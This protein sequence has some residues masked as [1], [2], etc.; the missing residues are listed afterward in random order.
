MRFGLL[1]QGPII[2]T[3]K[4]GKSITLQASQVKDEHIVSHDSKVTIGHIL[5]NYRHLF[6]EILVS[7]WDDYE[8]GDYNLDGVNIVKLKE[9]N[10]N[11]PKRKGFHNAV[12]SNNMLRQFYG[13]SKGLNTF[14]N[15]VDFIIRVRTDQFLNLE[16][17]VQFI[18]EY[19]CSGKIIIP[20]I[21][22][23]RDFVPDFYFAGEFDLLKDFFNVL[24]DPTDIISFSP[25]EQIVLKYAKE[26]YFDK[27]GVDKKWY[28]KPRAN[29]TSKIF[30]YML[31]NVFCP[32]PKEVYESVIW[33]GESWAD[34]YSEVISTYCF[35]N[36]SLYNKTTY[37]SSYDDLFYAKK[38]SY[39][40]KI[41]RK[42]SRI[43][44]DILLY[45]NNKFESNR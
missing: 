12:R 36:P 21:I 45:I 32:A 44:F 35:T 18:I 26:K 4:H 38:Y 29:E 15:R 8:N 40:G 3:G 28:T 16:L 22:R 11:L 6:T 1:I 20:Y 17:L 33:R 27:I 19:N 5:N 13:I 24:N 25:H 37:T 23:G 31:N 43:V 42:I 2:S 39:V 9:N 30:N 34:E 14:K 7:T 10:L 41:L